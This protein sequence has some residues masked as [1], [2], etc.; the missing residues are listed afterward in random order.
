MTTLIMKFGM[1]PKLPFSEGA[2]PTPFQSDLTTTN[3]PSIQTPLGNMKQVVSKIQ[4]PTSHGLL[5]PGS[6][7]RGSGYEKVPSKSPTETSFGSRTEK[8]GRLRSENNMLQLAVLKLV[9]VQVLKHQQMIEELMEQ[10]QK[11]R[12]GEKERED[13][14][15]WF[16]CI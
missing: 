9:F 13:K 11:L 7:S 1:A 6:I 10:N 14:K 3:E 12:E 16:K 5:G 4:D 2:F 8:A 15:Y